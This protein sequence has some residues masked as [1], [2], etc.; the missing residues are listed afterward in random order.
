MNVA[1]LMH[2]PDTDPDLD[3]VKDML[4]IFAEQNYPEPVTIEQLDSL[5]HM[6]KHRPEQLAD[7]IRKVRDQTLRQFLDQRYCPQ[8]GAKALKTVYAGYGYIFQKCDSCG[9]EW[10]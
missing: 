4:F 3:N 5:L 7:E 10:E 1:L 2:K 8:C 6:V 9:S